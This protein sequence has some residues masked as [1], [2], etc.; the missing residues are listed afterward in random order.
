[1]VEVRRGDL[2]LDKLELVRRGTSGGTRLLLAQLLPEA[3]ADA[4]DEDD[5]D[6]LS[7]RLSSPA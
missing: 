4:P 1:M 3:E 2:P 6:L 5:D 7:E